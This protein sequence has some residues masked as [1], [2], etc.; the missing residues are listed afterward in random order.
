MNAL[1]INEDVDDDDKLNSQQK[2][3]ADKNAWKRWIIVLSVFA[4]LGA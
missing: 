2:Q 4:L 1:T 3:E